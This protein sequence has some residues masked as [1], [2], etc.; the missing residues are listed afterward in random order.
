MELICAND[1]RREA[2]RSLSG[3][4]GLDYVEVDSDDR[5]VLRVFFLGALPKE[6]A[7]DRPGL[8]RYLRIEG[9]ERITDLRILDAD[10]QGASNP[11]RDS[12][13]SL[14]LDRSGDF[15]SYT[16]RLTGVEGIDPRYEAASFS[17]VIGCPSEL[18]CRPLEV[19]APQLD[20]TPPSHYLAKD[21]AS[22]RQLMLDRLAVLMP[23]WSERHAP[24]LGITLV[25]LLAYA[26][27]QLSYYQDA[28][29]TEAYLGTARQRISVRRHARL[30]DYALHEGCNARAW[31]H[32][33]VSGKLELPADRVAFV[34]GLSDPARD[35][36]APLS[37]EDLAALPAGS[38]EPYEPLLAPQIDTIALEPAHNEIAFYSW[39]RRE[40]C[41]LKGATSAS[42]LDG[43]RSSSQGSDE[44]ERA[45]QI[46]VGDVLIFEEVLGPLTGL[47]ADADPARRCAVRVTRV[48][49]AVDPV[50]PVAFAAAG[51]ELT[52][53]ATASG[54]TLPTPVLEIEWHAQD[55]LP[56]ALCVSALGAAPECAYVERVSVAR[57]NVILVD[58]GRSLPPEDLGSV[59]QVNGAQCCEC[60]GQPQPTRRK[61]GRYRPWLSSAPVTHREALPSAARAASSITVQDLRNALPQVQ[62]RDELGAAWHARRDLIASDAEERAF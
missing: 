23:A 47:A 29:A 34:T 28:V 20:E 51:T 35:D 31:L 25:E 56:F 55:A 24:D 2:V 45:L 1:P 39:G 49:R 15:S 27:D 42:L 37:P 58:H 21:Y 59:P 9:G 10:P 5:R 16:L 19:C 12:V 3:R 18:D 43:W 7:R 36:S 26:A 61:A 17:F 6:L 48:E 57:A 30:V 22:F 44:P 50:Y 54:N 46:A 52:A 8:E 41:L 60:E 13:L 14:R 53:G 33:H 38:Y 40:C 32:L 4:N 11:E 62:L